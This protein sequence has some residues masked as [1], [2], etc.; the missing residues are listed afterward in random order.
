MAKGILNYANADIG[1]GITG[2]AGPGC[3]ENKPVGLVYIALAD[4][5]SAWV[6]KLNVTGATNDRDKVR[7]SATVNALNMI[8]RYLTYLPN[9]MPNETNFNNPIPYK[10]EETALSEL[11]IKGV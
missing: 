1:V 6:M 7:E 10:P 4:K 5:E 9:K 8:R 11:A 2:V 3:S